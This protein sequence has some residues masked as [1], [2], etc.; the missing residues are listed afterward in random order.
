MTAQTWNPFLKFLL[1]T[2]NIPPLPLLIV[3]GIQLE[4]F[5]KARKRMRKAKNKS[6]QRTKYVVCSGAVYLFIQKGSFGGNWRV[7]HG[8]ITGCHGHGFCVW[9]DMCVETGMERTSRGE[10]EKVC[11]Y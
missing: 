3:A 5:K 6:K 8:A 10:K 1:A 4:A 11:K 7:S 9:T 2:V